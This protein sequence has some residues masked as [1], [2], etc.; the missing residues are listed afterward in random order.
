MTTLPLPPPYVMVAVSVFARLN[1][2]EKAL[3]EVVRAKL[4][5]AQ[6]ANP[7]RG[8][9]PGG[10]Y[11]EPR[12]PVLLKPVATMP[13]YRGKADWCRWTSIGLPLP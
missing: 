3:A 9:Q 1:D 11:A 10:T 8:L 7:N 2:D 13:R 12:P 6:P 4:E 5:E